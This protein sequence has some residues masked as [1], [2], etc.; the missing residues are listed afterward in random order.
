[1][2]E[3]RSAI[4]LVSVSKRYET[5]GYALQKVDFT[6]YPGESVAVTGRSGSGKSTML[7][8]MGLLDQPD[9]GEVI[10]HG[11]PA[12]G[13]DDRRLSDLRAHAIG[14]VFQRANL[15][16]GL[17][18]SENVQLGLIYAGMK[19]SEASAQADNAL[20]S[21]GLGHRTTALA[22][23][24]SGGEMQRVAIART[25]AR[26]S[27]IW[28]ADE[29]TGNLDSRQSI[30]MIEL[31]KS[32]AR[33]VG[34]AL[35]VVTHEPDIA[36]RLDRVVVLSD[37]ALEADSL[38]MSSTTTEP[39]VASLAGC[40]APR[41]GKRLILRRTLHFILSDLAAHPRRAAAGIAASTIAV[42]L[43][44]VALGLAQSAAGQVTEMF[45]AQRA[46]T[47]TAEFVIDPTRPARWPL[48]TASTASFPGVVAVEQWRY[49]QDVTLTNGAVETTSAQVIVVDSAPAVATSSS[50]SW[51]RPD[52][53]LGVDEIVLGSLLARRLHLTQPELTPEV[54]INGRQLRVVG[55]VS[56]SRVPA[57]EGSAFV[58][59]S[60][61]L[62]L[63][64]ATTTGVFITTLAGGAQNVASRLQDL[65]D[66]YRFY[67][68]RL[69]PILQPQSF[70]GQLESSVSTSL[71]VMAVISSLAG[72]VGIVFVNIL[73]V[74]ARVPEL[75]VRR[76]FGAR[77]GELVGLIIGE[78]CALGAVGAV[79]GL[80]VGFLA[81]MVVT[82]LS[83]WQPIFDP[84]LVAAPLV[85]ALV[86]GLLG[87]LPPA[88]SAGRVQ[89]ADAVRL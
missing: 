80:G 29:P 5:S 24:L 36:E 56:S 75:G 44:V 55:I 1:M 88:V 72:L 48:S 59:P 2:A 43:I 3:A 4:R 87:G 89:P 57:G 12:G 54:S 67:T 74:Q 50:I 25:L 65:I 77:R 68:M 62:G 8:M 42:A 64:P 28:L 60:T 19:K 58:L 40:E 37:G 30:D 71:T 81:I 26:P 27:R 31:L 6:V 85:A 9:E 21:V 86:F 79:I 35:I 49:H 39:E 32:R 7:N 34:A 41:A 73:S 38:V 53:R 84:R 17:T 23:V 10:I 78:S 11:T 66:P 14:F 52:K 76:A 63:P 18:V 13:L 45:N 33:D 83:R 82:L 51:F 61:H 70:H 20:R 69:D 47:V 16:G 46:A 15:I 22:R